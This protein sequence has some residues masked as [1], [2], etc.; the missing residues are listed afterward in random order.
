MWLASLPMNI[1]SILAFLR[2]FRLA[3]SPSRNDSPA[4]HAL[5]TAADTARQASSPQSGAL[6]EL[7]LIP[8][9]PRLHSCMT[10]SSNRMS[11]SPVCEFSLYASHARCRHVRPLMSS[12]LTSAPFSKSITA[13]FTFARIAAWCRGANHVPL[14]SSSRTALHAASSFADSKM[15]SRLSTS[16]ASMAFTVALFGCSSSMAGRDVATWRL[17]TR[18]GRQVR[19]ARSG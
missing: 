16:S 18:I 14:S 9:A 7:H 6:P 5:S 1:A 19:A 13:H 15:N 11:M 8:T 12:L 3:S 2:A 10:I 4:C 17:R